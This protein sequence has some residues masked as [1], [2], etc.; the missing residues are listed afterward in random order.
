MTKR[1]NKCEGAGGMQ[2]C[3]MLAILSEESKETN[4]T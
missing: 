2:G 4:G 1:G 3:M